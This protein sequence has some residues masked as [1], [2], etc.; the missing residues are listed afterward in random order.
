MFLADDFDAVGG[1]VF[2][3]HVRG[4]A[5]ADASP[6]GFFA[7]PFDAAAGVG[8]LFTIVQSTAASNDAIGEVTSWT[9]KDITRGEWMGF[10]IL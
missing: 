3:P 9:L 8:E 4:E 5:I 2:G 7:A 6:T 10:W 1:A